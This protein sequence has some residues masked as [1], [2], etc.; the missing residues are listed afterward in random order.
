MRLR[1]DYDADIMLV[2]ADKVTK[3]VSMIYAYRR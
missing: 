2:I 3:V 1:M